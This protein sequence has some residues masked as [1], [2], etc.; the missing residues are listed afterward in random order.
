VLSLLFFGLNPAQE[1]P[2]NHGASLDFPNAKLPSLIPLQ[3]SFAVDDVEDQLRNL[4]ID[5]FDANLSVDAFDINALGMAHLGSFGLVKRMVNADGLVLL[6]GD[7]EEPATRYVYR[8]WKSRNVQGR[9]LYFLKT[10]LQSLFPGVWSV[11]QQM[12]EIAQPYPTALSDRSSTGN[13]ADKF[14]TSRLSIKL[15]SAGNIPDVSGLIPIIS[16]I[17]PARFV[18]KMTV[19]SYGATEMSIAARGNPAITLRSTGDILEPSYVY[20][21]APALMASI[22]NPAIT[23]RSSGAVTI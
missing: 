4:F 6:P 17:V 3:H 8:A 15:D 10:Y 12:Q 19:V 21:D 22:G 16:A 13:D 9:G 7:R 20:P 2:I 11:E 1:P 5:L 18:P 23:L 14:L